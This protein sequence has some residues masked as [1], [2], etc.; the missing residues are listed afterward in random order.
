MQ[1]E[2]VKKNEG[3]S[4]KKSKALL[5]E[6]DKLKEKLERQHEKYKWKYSQELVA[7]STVIAQKLA[8]H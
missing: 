2:S 4:E 7:T 6:I 5:S 1:A 8:D 3:S